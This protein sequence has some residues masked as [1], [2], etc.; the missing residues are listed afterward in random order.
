MG[1][2]RSASLV[3]VAVVGA[4]CS[5]DSAPRWRVSG[6]F[7][8]DPAGRA[9]ILRGINVSAEHKHPPYFDFQGPDD[10]ARIR[11]DWGFNAVRFLIEWAAIEPASGGIAAAYLDAVAERMGWARDAGLLVVLDLH[12]DLYGEG[13]A[14]GNGAPRWTCDDARYAAFQPTTPWFLNYLDPNVIACFDGLWS[15]AELQGHVA[16]AWRAV[17]A[18]LAACPNV[19][20]FDPLNEPF[21]GSHPIDRFEAETLG[22]FY[23]A[24]VASVRAEAPWL[25]FVEPASSRNVGY[26]SGLRVASADVVYAPH[27]YDADAESGGGFDP[28]HRAGYIANVMALADEARA[29][30]AALWIGEY[31]GVASAGGIGEYMDAAGD[32]AGM[33]AAG[34]AYWHYGR[35]SGYGL[36]DASGAEKPQLVAALV[37][38]Y[39][40]RVAGDPVSWSWGDGRFTLVYRPDRAISAPTEIMLPSRVFPGGARWECDGC[41]AT[42]AGDVLAV[43]SPPEGATA[44]LVVYPL[45]TTPVTGR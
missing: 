44:T 10:Y 3:A 1:S 15:S 26:P 7:V 35:D 20:G 23:D 30:G 31:G 16:A 32:A 24:V 18:R 11:R 9:A 8:R 5:G 4:A 19:V 28:M 41:A 45:S 33:A 42:T 29:M 37:R 21:W 2:C 40:A 17:A 38:P 13:F 34:G 6:G 25:A 39:P 22:P 27:A 36:L 14:G 43:T 12:Q